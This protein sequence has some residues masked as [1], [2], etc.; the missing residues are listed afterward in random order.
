MFKSVF[1]IFLFSSFVYPQRIVSLLPSYTEII[2]ELGAGDKLVGVTNFC[3]YPEQ[4]KKKDKVGDYLNPNIEKI[5]KLKP[6]II[7]MGEW[8]NDFIKKIK[9]L[10]AK[11]VV[12]NQ[13]KSVEDIYKTIKIISKHINKEK[14]G[15]EIIA[16]MKKEIDSSKNKSYVKVYAEVDRDLWSVGSDSFISDVISKSGGI[17][18]FNDIKIPYFKAQWEEVVKRNP[19]AVIL[20]STGYSEFVSRPLADKIKAAKDKKIYVLTPE[21]RNLFSRPSPRI[22]EVIKKVSEY[23]SSK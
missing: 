3:D 2:F 5:Y 17:N 11:T 13:E 14:K 21:E 20:F 16:R 8:R 10:K 19:D 23:L 12:I 9:N 15:N 1:L 4:A 22:A 6:D 18:I 7:F